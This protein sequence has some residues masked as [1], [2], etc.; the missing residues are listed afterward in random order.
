MKRSGIEND[1]KNTQNQ[2]N[3]KTQVRK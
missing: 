2:M 1:A 3:L